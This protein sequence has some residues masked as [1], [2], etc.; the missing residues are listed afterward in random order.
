VVVEYI[1]YAIPSERSE[2]FQAGYA[3]AQSA[4]AASSHCLG[5]ELSRGVEEPGNFIL[6]IEWDS[7]EGHEQGFRAGPEF[8]TFFAAVRPFFDQILEMKHYEVTDIAG[9]PS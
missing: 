2:E 4:L 8:R 5:W 7:I 9:G 6:R 3:R 1:R